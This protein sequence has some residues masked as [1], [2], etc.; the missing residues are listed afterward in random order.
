MRESN[1]INLYLVFGCTGKSR[2]FTKKAM[3]NIQL[4]DGDQQEKVNEQI[5]KHDLLITAWTDL[6]GAT[7]P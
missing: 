4:R 3:L 7:I 2:V 5:Q 6:N 1:K